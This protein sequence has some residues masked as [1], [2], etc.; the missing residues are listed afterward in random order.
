GW[1]QLAWQ[2]CPPDVPGSSQAECALAEVPLDWHAGE[3]AAIRV[4][5]RR[6]RPEGPVRGQLWALDGGPG[7]AGDGFVAPQFRQTVLDAG[8]ELIV[9]SHRG[10]AYGTTLACPGARDEASCVAELFD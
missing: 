6:F 5:C 1:T 9:P 8:Y 3:S 7:E 2:D 4:F 10:S